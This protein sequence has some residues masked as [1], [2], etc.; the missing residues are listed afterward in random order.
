M[1]KVFVK[2]LA[3]QLDIM[4]IFLE[5]W[6]V[7]LFVHLCLKIYML[8]SCDVNALDQEKRCQNI[9]LLFNGTYKANE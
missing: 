5:G 7:F 6:G 2:F 1:A 9:S 8:K 4:V 3:A